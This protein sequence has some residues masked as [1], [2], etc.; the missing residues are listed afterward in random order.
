VAAHNVVTVLI[1]GV[2]GT[3]ERGAK[4]SPRL[5]A[6]TVAGSTLKTVTRGWRRN[7]RFT[8]GH[9]GQGIA[10]VFERL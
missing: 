1:A 3:N 8:S 2:R 4:R 7:E 5:M 10:A 6:G 9:R